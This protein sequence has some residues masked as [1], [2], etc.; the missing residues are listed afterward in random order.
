MISRIATALAIAGLL[1]GTAPV[2]AQEQPVP[3][4]PALGPDGVPEPPAQAV[5]KG[6]L[7]S[8]L[9]IL[10]HPDDEIMLGPVIYRFARE[11]G[12]VRVIFAT[13]GDAGPG[14]SGMEPGQELAEA[15]ENEARCAA[16]ALGIDEPEFWKLGD[17]TLAT[18]ARADRSSAKQ[19]LGM[20][21][22]AIALT[23]PDVVMTW[24]PDGGY[25][26]ADHRTISALVTQ[27]IGSMTK[28]RPDLLYTA[29][30]QT[31]EDAL[32][33]FESWAAT[34]PDLL[35]DRIRY[36]PV[37]LNAAQAAL[38]CYQSQF[39]ESERAALIPMLHRQV[40]RGAL[41]FRLAF[42]NAARE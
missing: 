37:D 41:H 30:P 35:T 17:G 5:R 40:W 25:G 39:S 13:S 19:A 4:A 27:V 9:I 23:K 3:Q 8:V 7:P 31:D 20:I 12:D 32:P 1:A 14:I 21:A 34:H 11:G 22:E 18:N 29:I 28:R 16:F 2:S 38:S 10:A 33:E 26:H 36:E 15:R 42:P 6:Q 24:G